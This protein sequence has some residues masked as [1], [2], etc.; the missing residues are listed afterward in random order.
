M[1]RYI[2]NQGKR[3][4]STAWLLTRRVSGD[5]ANSMN[6]TGGRTL[7]CERL[8]DSLGLHRLNRHPDMN[9]HRGRPQ[10]HNIASAVGIRMA[11]GTLLSCL[12]FIPELINS[13]ESRR[14]GK[15]L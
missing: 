15:M 12:F 14:C 3:G 10:R 11:A 1:T 8:P 6:T 7:G 9:R 4:K 5:W 13:S 2:G